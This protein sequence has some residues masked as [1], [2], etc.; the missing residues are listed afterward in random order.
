[1]AEEPTDIELERKMAVED[2]WMLREG[3]KA[4]DEDD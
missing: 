2:D 1:M 4:E 3:A